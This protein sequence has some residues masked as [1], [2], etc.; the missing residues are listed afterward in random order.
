MSVNAL[1]IRSPCRIL[2]MACDSTAEERRAL[3]VLLSCMPSVESSK[4][5]VKKATHC[6]IRVDH[7]LDPRFALLTRRT[8]DFSPPTLELPR[9]RT[10][11]RDT[12][13]PFELVE[14]QLLHELRPRI[15]RCFEL[16]DQVLAVRVVVEHLEVMRADEFVEILLR[17]F[18]VGKNSVI[19][20]QDDFG[21]RSE[22]GAR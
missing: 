19:G 10:L 6:C 7:R 2:G 1:A 17:L 22:Q 13:P 14:R 11:V 21:G 12:R 18:H 4:G 16:L 20:C 8:D 5:D 3:S 15:G 9:L